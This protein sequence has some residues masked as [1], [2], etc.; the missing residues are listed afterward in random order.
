MLLR[1]K[2]WFW[3]GRHFFSPFFSEWH[4]I[5]AAEGWL[6]CLW[7]T[8]VYLSHVRRS[9]EKLC[10]II[11]MV[12]VV[13]VRML[14]SCLINIHTQFH[15]EPTTCELKI[16]L[17]LCPCFVWMHCCYIFLFFLFVMACVYKQDREK[18]K[19]GL[20]LAAVHTWYFKTEVV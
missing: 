17:A 8:R 19:I 1:Q 3:W 5:S 7:R 6:Y 15:N 13:H 14:L 2:G 16:L 10:L 12:Q 4:I 18:P 20:R 11:M 9:Q